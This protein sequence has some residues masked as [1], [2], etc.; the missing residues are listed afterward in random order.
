M[1]LHS[2][3]IKLLDV[4][5]LPGGCRGCP[6]VFHAILLIF[7]SLSLISAHLPPDSLLVYRVA[8]VFVSVPL[9]A[10]HGSH[11]SPTLVRGV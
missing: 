9:D 7:H 1:S 8:S 5:L 6:C 10:H 3:V 2:K 4:L 11:A